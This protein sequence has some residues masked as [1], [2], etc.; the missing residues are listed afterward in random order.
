MS[1]VLVVEDDAQMRSLLARYLNRLGH[2]VQGASTLAEG[3]ALQAKEAPDLII[4]DYN[5]PDGNAFDLLGA[6]QEQDSGEAVIVLTGVGT[7]DLAVRAIKA[8]A[9]H[10]LTKPVDLESLG[11]L[12]QRTLE[13]QRDKRQ[14]ALAAATAPEAANPFLGTSRQMRALRELAE[15]VLDSDAPVLLRGETGSG[16]GVLAR[17]L[18]ANGPRKDEPFVDLNCAG[19]SLELVQSELFGHRRGAFTGAVSNKPGLLEV[20]H[21]GTLFLDE[22]G[23]LELGVQP[24]LLKVLEE[25]TFRRLGDP[26]S[27]SADVRLI[28]A[29]HKN[30]GAMVEQNQFRSD[31]LFR[32]N[33]LVLELPALR[34]RDEDLRALA[35]VLLSQLSRKSGRV[36][37]TL[38]PD[39]LDML[40]DYHWPGN[41]RELRNVLERA[42]LFCKTDSLDR[43]ALR[44][45]RS[46]DPEE[47]SHGL[48]L[49]EVERRHIASV[50]RGAQGSVEKAAEVLQLSRSALYVKLKKYGIKA[51]RSA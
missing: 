1:T 50:L 23:D 5:L 20:A 4:V 43:K 47:K 38:G 10:F 42:L 39:A 26:S 21:R 8:G 27:R 19:L 24:K 28:A 40:R 44:F 16:K 22:I 14:R 48:S 36:T 12:V 9:E 7:I 3:R 2:E 15:A 6:R 46:L 18:H 11:V 31:L 33:T 35:E 32:I 30:L 37:P 17:W 51:E 13:A 29:T 45:D 34:E 25:G 41:V 49:E